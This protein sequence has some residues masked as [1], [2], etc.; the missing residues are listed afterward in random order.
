M[1]F[2]KSP[3]MTMQELEL[4]T[5]AMTVYPVRAVRL[6]L[7]ANHGLKGKTQ[8]KAGDGMCWV[9]E[10]DRDPNHGL[11]VGKTPKR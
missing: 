5:N 4:T 7:D 1:G 11:G 3:R 8:L 2:P 6:A 9:R 10:C